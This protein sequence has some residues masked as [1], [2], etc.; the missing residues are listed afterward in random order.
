MLLM[1]GCRLD[2]VTDPAMYKMVDGGIRGGVWISKRKGR[3]NH[4]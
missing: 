4:P 1:T 3:A 2:L